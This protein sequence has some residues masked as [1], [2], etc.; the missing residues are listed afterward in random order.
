MPLILLL[1]LL[2]LF[3]PLAIDIYLPAI[4]QMAEQL[5]AE[6]TL[7]QGTITWFLF[8]MGLGQ[9]LVGP[10]ADRYGRKPIALGG[11]LLYG[12]SALGAG[13]AAS[14]GELMLARVLQGFGAC[15]TSVAAFSVVRDSY[16]PKKSGQMISY[17]NGAICFIPALAPLL[18]GWLTAKAGWSANF[19]FMAGYA[20]IVGSWL[21]W[22][23]PET[24]PEETS[25]SGPLISWSRYSPVLRSPSFLFNATLCMLAMAVILAYVTAAPVQLMVKLGLDMSGFSYWFTANAALNILACFLA[26]R[27]IARVGP[28]RTLRIGLLVLLLSAIALT[29]AMHIEHPLAMMGP[30]FLSSIGFAMI[31]GAAAGMALAP[32]GHCAGTAAALLGLFQ[33][34][35]SGALVGFIGMLMHDP[36]SQLALHM[37]LLLPPLLMLMTR[38]GRRLCLQ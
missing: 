38:Q 4:P 7:M 26:P 20:V 3:S 27:F 23:M 11:V 36:L 12:L 37:W 25:S 22:R 28:R 30:V 24:R 16:G 9:L 29:L 19:W 1:V 15:A 14:L 32:F 34:S 17:L 2:V 33:M 8:S 31:L 18:G 21:L 35:G 5:G 6:V 10:L 13:F